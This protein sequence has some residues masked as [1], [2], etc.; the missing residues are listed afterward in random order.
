[1]NVTLILLPF[2]NL[3]AAL[4]LAH[5]FAHHF[6]DCNSISNIRFLLRNLRSMKAFHKIRRLAFYYRRRLPV[7]WYAGSW[8]KNNSKTRGS[9]KLNARRKVIGYYGYPYVVARISTSAS[10]NK[11]HKV[12]VGGKRKL[13]EKVVV[14]SCP[15]ARTIHEIECA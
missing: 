1:M 7:L 12:I 11:K 8:R 10:Q 15:N 4:Q 2:N 3:E 5:Q 14:N 13:M 9:L 6:F